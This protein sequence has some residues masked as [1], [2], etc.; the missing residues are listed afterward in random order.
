MSTNRCRD[1]SLYLFHDHTSCLH[2]MSVI[3]L[4]VYNI[5]EDIKDNE[6]MKTFLSKKNILKL[7]GLHLKVG[8]HCLSI[9]INVYD[10]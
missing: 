8:S 3:K 4:Y 6:Y 1:I 2:I 7:T 5:F 10:N 9:Q